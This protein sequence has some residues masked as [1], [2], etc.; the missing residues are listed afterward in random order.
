MYCKGVMSMY[1]SMCQN[2]SGLQWAKF[3]LWLGDPPPPM[4][5]ESL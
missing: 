2:N 5:N 4:N 3:E 1:E